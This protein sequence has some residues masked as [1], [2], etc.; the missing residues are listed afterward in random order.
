MWFTLMA[1]GLLVGGVRAAEA[2]V[3][4]AVPAPKAAAPV[5]ATAWQ[6]EQVKLALDEYKW[7][8]AV[9]RRSAEYRTPT[10][11]QIAIYKLVLD[12]NRADYDMHVK[13]YKQLL[14]LQQD[15]VQRKN[16]VAADQFAALAV[17]YKQY[18]EQNVVLVTAIE[19]EHSSTKL[20][21]AFKAIKKLETDIAQL[22]NGK[23]PK[24]S[25]LMP[26]ELTKIWQ[27]QGVV[28]PPPK[29]AAPAPRPQGG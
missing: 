21:A 28:K 14:E 17:L 1:A 26:E 7:R 5:Q 20:E 15:A 25:W 12:A 8:M 19:K 11:R 29:A 10:E 2:Q 16:V 6:P 18:A 22:N 24:R 3:A 27:Q 4:A 13:A 9:A 23:L